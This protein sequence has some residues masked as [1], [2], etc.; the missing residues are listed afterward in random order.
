MD[1]HVRETLRQRLERALDAIDRLRPVASER[2]FQPVAVGPGRPSRRH[3]RRVR[4]VRAWSRLVR[5]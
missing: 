1:D 5:I 2:A 4:P 3:A